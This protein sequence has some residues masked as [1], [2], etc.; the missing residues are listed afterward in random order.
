MLARSS[1]PS[2]CGLICLAVPAFSRRH[3]P[4]PP[5]TSLV[6]FS[7]SSPP[8]VIVA[9]FRALCSSRVHPAAILVCRTSVLYFFSLKQ[10]AAPRGCGLAPPFTLSHR[11]PLQHRQLCASSIDR[12]RCAAALL[13]APLLALCPFLPT[14]HNVQTPFV[15]RAVELQDPFPLGLEDPAMVVHLRPGRPGRC[16]GLVCSLFLVIE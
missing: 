8:S 16:R 5:L 9:P 4:R 3:R 10:T 14:M 13:F 7:S 2:P 1:Q 12:D 15:H 11:I 6:P